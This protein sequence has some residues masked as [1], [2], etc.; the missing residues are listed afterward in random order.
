MIGDFGNAS[1]TSRMRETLRHP[2]SRGGALLDKRASCRCRRH[3][4]CYPL[5]LVKSVKF[6]SLAK[7]IG[8][9]IQKYKLSRRLPGSQC[10]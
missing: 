2:I 3:P 1:S 9:A 5:T 8:S 10:L 4:L 6:Q 7:D